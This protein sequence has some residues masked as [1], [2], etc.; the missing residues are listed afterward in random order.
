MQC[1]S[2]S[3]QGVY[4]GIQRVQFYPH[5]NRLYYPS[6]SQACPNV[7]Q[8]TLNQFQHAFSFSN[9]VL[10]GERA[11]RP[12]RL[13]ALLIV[14]F[15]T[16]VPANSRSFW[17][18]PQVVL[19]SWTTLLIIIF[20]PL[21]ETRSWPVYAEMMFF[22]LPDYGPNSAHWNIQKFRNASATNAISMF[23]NNKESS[24][25]LPIMRCF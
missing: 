1:H 2:A 19:G 6:I 15:E 4:Y 12:W 13:S 16:I 7:V 10:C 20:T 17:S 23:C 18:S 8:Q 24:L 9:G 3:K 22:P 5:L 14:F 21:S 11:Y 25:L